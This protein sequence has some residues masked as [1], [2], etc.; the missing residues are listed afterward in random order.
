MSKMVAARQPLHVELERVTA[1]GILIVKEI[2]NVSR[3]GA[4]LTFLNGML[5]SLTNPGIAA[6]FQLEFDQF[7]YLVKVYQ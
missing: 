5:E 4:L 7:N 3:T 2:W 6:M 1:M